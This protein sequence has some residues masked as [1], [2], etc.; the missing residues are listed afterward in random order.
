MLKLLDSIQE[1]EIY[2]CSLLIHL[3]HLLP[4]S[5]SNSLAAPY[6]ETLIWYQNNVVLVKIKLQHGLRF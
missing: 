5:P 6:V 4:Y 3:F 2:M 1:L